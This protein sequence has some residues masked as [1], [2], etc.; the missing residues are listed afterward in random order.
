MIFLFFRGEISFIDI[1][2]LT[3][4]NI[5]EGNFYCKV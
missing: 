4:K 2:Y 5:K 1:A 3:Q